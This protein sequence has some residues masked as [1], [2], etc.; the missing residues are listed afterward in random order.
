MTG[1]M[2]WPAA[3]PIA[4][5]GNAAA[6]V[7]RAA[8]CN[9]ARRVRASGRDSHCRSAYRSFEF[10][11]STWIRRSY[12]ASTTRGQSMSGYDEMIEARHPRIAGEGDDNPRFLW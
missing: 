12:E 2:P 4:M 11:F 10:T 3:A 8:F 9:N 5:G 1:L 7:M 6:A